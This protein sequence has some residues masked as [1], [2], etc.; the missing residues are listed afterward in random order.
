V[1][2]SAERADAVEGA[3]KGRRETR[4][5]R[6]SDPLRELRD[7]ELGYAAG[8]AP[9]PGAVF[10][11]T[12]WAVLNEPEEGH[13]VFACGKGFDVEMRSAESRIKRE[14]SD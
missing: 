13:V 1:A 9:W 3:G 8:P 6:A 11:D 12:R 4:L 7:V 14:G 5:P 2:V 10:E